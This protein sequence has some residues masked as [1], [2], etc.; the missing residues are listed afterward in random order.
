MRV[1]TRWR[2]SKRERTPEEIATA[3]AVVIWK[4]ASQMVLTLENEGFETESNPQRLDVFAETGAYML[5]LVDRMLYGR[6][7]DEE[8]ARFVTA[9]A[10]SLAQ[11]IQ[12]NRGLLQGAG[13]YRTPFIELL[14]QR[15]AEYSESRWEE[16]EGPSFVMRRNFGNHVSEKMGPRDRKWIT[17]YVMDVE[18]PKLLAAL[19]QAVPGLLG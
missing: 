14:N 16:D 5:Q 17:D 19:K 18:A 8:R 6:K 3:L 10:R 7:T 1:R 12:E 9:L 4:A 2:D 15:G 13:D 11:L